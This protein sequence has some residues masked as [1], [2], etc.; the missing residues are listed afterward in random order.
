MRPYL[1][2]L[3]FLLFSP[4]AAAWNAAGHR[5]VAV[6]AW[7]QLSPANRDF[8]TQALGRHPDHER[9]VSKARSVESG[10]IFAEAATRPWPN[11]NRSHPRWRP[12]CARFWPQ[13]GNPAPSSTNRCSPG[14][15]LS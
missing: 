13:T 12:N 14:R 4:L 2:A 6:I 7:Q 3:L 9:W 5:L 11:W 8:V 10:K 15:S 1:I